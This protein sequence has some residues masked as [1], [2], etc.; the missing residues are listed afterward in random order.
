MYTLDHPNVLKFN[1]WYETGKHIWLIIEYATGGDMM[2]LLQEDG[3]LPEESVKKFAYDIISGLHYVHHRGYIYADLKPSNILI[4]EYGVLKLCDFGLSMPIPITAEDQT[5]RSKTGTPYYMAPEL[6]HSQGVHSFASDLWALGCLLYEFATGVVPFAHTGV[7]ELVHAI[8]NDE[9]EMVGDEFSD[10]FVD[11]LDLCLQK[12][13]CH[14]LRWEELL[15][16]P[17]WGDLAPFP[18]FDLPTQPLR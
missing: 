8:L 11:L 7:K 13:P 14:R 2:T 12:D 4:N 18:A 6:F 16:H 3:R 10:E 17:W 15:S 1:T 9:W 5:K